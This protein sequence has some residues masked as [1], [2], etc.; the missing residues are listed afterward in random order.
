MKA[1]MS[2]LRDLV[3]LP[4]GTDTAT[5]AARF[6]ALGLTV[7]HVTSTGPDITGP[8]V[9]GRVLS[10]S[11]EPQKNGKVIRYCRVD[12]GD[13]L[14]D[15]ASEE[16][17]ASRGIVCG[18]HNFAVGDLVVVVLP[19]A[20]LPGGFEISA[21]KTYGHIS[22][23]MI[24][25][26]LELGLGED[27]DGI[28]VLD[29][30]LGAAVG[31]DAL[32]LLWTQ[33]EVLEMEVTPDL[34]HG[35]SMRGL[36]REAASA[37]GVG[38]DD[39]YAIPMPENSEAGQPVVLESDRAV[40]FVALTIEGFDPAAPSPKFMV[41]RLVASGVRSI[42]LPVDVTNYV[43]LESGQPLHAYDAAGLQGTIRVRQAHEGEQLRTLDGV[44]RDLAPD[45]LLITDDSGPIG[46]AGVMGGEATEVKESTTSIVLEAAHFDGPSV[47][48]TFRR[49]GLF[50]EASKRFERIVDP[51]VPYAAARRAAE[52]LVTHG[53]GTI[54]PE[55]TYVGKVPAK[56]R[57]NLRSGL[58]PAI[59]GAD[60]PVS[61]SIRILQASGLGVTA[62]GD[63]LSLEV[64][65]W[66]PD[67]RDPYDI[68]EEVGR[69]FGYDRIG[70]SMPTPPPGGGLTRRQKDA[71]RV[72]AAVAALGFTEVL[73]LPFVSADDVDALGV[74]PDDP[75]RKLVR[76]ANP[77][78]D[79][80]PFLRTSLLPGLFRAVAKNTSRSNDDL[81]LF[82][83]GSGYF[84]SGT[85]DAPRPDLSQRP[86]DEELAAL[87]AALPTQPDT[88]AAVVTGNWVTAGWDG[89]AVPADW[90]HVVAFAE[91]AAAAVGLRISRVNDDAAMPWH[92]GRCARLV[93]GELTIGF[94]GELHPEVVR[95]YGLPA[96]TCAVEF[97]LGDLLAAA[98]AGGTIAAISGFPVAKEDVALVV[99]E[100]VAAADVRAALV[101][102]AGELLESVVLFDVYR[103]DQI[104]DGKKSLAFAMRFR[105]ER[106]L[107]DAEAA[108][109]RN[110][111]VAVAAERF[112]AVQRA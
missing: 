102:G 19:G 28:R 103:G 89:R 12:V 6:T 41:D 37:A 86:S 72:L 5:V 70:R 96:R 76:L 51:G 27:H 20:V 36:A 2:W 83:R 13:E 46:L 92:P 26:D 57:L 109:A 16:F 81:A 34:S 50:S 49:H 17:P 9:V 99:D 66:R 73:S 55:Y 3:A 84:D 7:E 22:D 77:L 68:V 53:G 25:S 104:P 94:A 15:P 95:A 52:L 39:P 40:N 80:Q 75:R 112:G 63:S 18:A 56:H 48:R 21:R 10:F 8:L 23:G 32:E 42:S 35:L 97:N 88:I 79:T 90:R 85:P 33:D 1:P 65:T 24:C 44:L 93:V 45:D 107:K 108:Q 74:A 61:D 69:K 105:A 54:R 110:A 87:E 59:L 43:M 98:P 29:P 14:N 30:S 4:E 106:T 62:L 64:P 82:E 58:I 78:D 67:L 31:D 101:E 111:A 47:S 11:D 91:T 100:A 71:R 60:V 38:F